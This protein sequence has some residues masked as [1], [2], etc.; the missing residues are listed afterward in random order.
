MGLDA[1]WCLFCLR[2]V[3]FG[4]Q[5]PGWY[6][7]QNGWHNEKNRQRRENMMRARA[8]ACVVK[9]LIGNVAVFCESCCPICTSVVDNEC[10][11][12]R[13]DQCD[14]WVH[15]FCAAI[16][17]DKGRT[18]RDVL[19]YYCPPCCAR[20]G[21]EILYRKSRKRKQLPSRWRWKE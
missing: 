13:C 14:R 21:L 2:N 19:R 15:G 11:S 4:A 5:Y 3:K 6:A 7:K 18:A 10:F 16:D 12:I 20:L 17:P 8:V 1:N 9:T